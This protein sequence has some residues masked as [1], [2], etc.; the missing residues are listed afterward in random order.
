MIYTYFHNWGWD[1]MAIPVG[2]VCPE[3]V[4]KF[5]VNVHAT[6]KEVGT[7]KSYVRG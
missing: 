4:R 7:L 3:L 6:N 5:Y 1:R 2:F